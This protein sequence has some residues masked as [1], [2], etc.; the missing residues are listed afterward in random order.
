MTGSATPPTE[1]PP[2]LPSEGVLYATFGDRLIAYLIDALL[3]A[4]IWYA[5]S[6]PLFLALGVDDETS[7]R[8]VGGVSLICSIV[9]RATYHAV[10]D[11]SRWQGTVGKQALG[12]KVVDLDGQRIGWARALGRYFASLLSTIVIYMGYLAA[13]SD[14]QV[15]TWHDRLAQTLVVKASAAPADGRA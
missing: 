6:I 1:P 7:P 5:I 8:L 3:L 4:G 13:T 10:L 14:R 15:R 9:I 2:E 11:S 12:I